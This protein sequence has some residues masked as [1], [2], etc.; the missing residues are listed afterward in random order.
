[1]TRGTL[2]L[3]DFEAWIEH[4][5]GHPVETYRPAW[6]NEPDAPDWE[7]PPAAKVAYLARLFED[8]APPL[9]HFADRQIAQ[10]LMYLLDN[11]A[12]DYVL[13]VADPALPPDLALRAVRAVEP[14][15]ARLLDPR[16]APVLSHLDE[17]GGGPLNGVAYMWWDICPI[18]P[19]P[20]AA[21][22]PLDEAMLETMAAILALPSP[23]SQESAL[24]GLGHWRGAGRGRAES[25]IDAYLARRGRD[26]RP[27]LRR[28]AEAA[29]TGCIL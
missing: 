2:T 12:G 28:Y 11:G 8:P 4:V 13:S 18:T 22:H 14:L 19:G 3:P 9:E 25:I 10:G 5:F 1:M 21:P 24:H 27:E 26:I 20:A 29:R 16:C 23:A 17:P 7:A 6:Y 15:F